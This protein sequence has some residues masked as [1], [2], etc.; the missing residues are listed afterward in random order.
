MEGEGAQRD[1]P[2]AHRAQPIPNGL[3]A[4]AGQVQ[5]ALSPCPSPWP[6]TLVPS[7]AAPPLPG[8]LLFSWILG[9]HPCKGALC[10][11]STSSLTPSCS[12][13]MPY[14]LAR[15]HRAPPRWGCTTQK[16]P[17]PCFQDL[18]A[19]GF[20]VLEAVKATDVIDQDVGMDAPEPPATHVRPLLQGAERDQSWLSPSA[21]PGD[22][23]PCPVLDGH[24]KEAAVAAGS[25]GAAHSPALTR[26]THLCSAL[27]QLCLPPQLCSHPPSPEILYLPC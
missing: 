13:S 23:L 4:V 27:T 20:D 11:S 19:D 12:P 15:S 9:S 10:Q 5:G 3:L 6:A 16:A 26:S 25:R 18:L 2:A 1:S 21:V 7:P 17:L 22:A 8:V 14:S 24:P